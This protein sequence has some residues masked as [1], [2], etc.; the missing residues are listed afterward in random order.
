MVDNLCNYFVRYPG[1]VERSEITE[2]LFSFLIGG[3]LTHSEAD[4]A[5]GRIPEPS[6]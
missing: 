6:V 5:A 1:A 3:L 2:F 4:K